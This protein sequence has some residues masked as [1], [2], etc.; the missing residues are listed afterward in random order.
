MVKMDL[1]VHKDTEGQPEK[2]VLMEIKALMDQLDIEDQMDKM[3][4]MEMKDH[5]DHKDIE[6]QMVMLD[7]MEGQEIVD[8]EEI[9]VLQANLVIVKTVTRIMII[10]PIWM[11]W[12]KDT[13]SQSTIEIDIWNEYWLLA[14]NFAMLI[15]I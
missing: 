13:L 1:M 11:K 5:K 14:Y 15:K 2:M 8:Q 4:L 3:E 12:E 10:M 9:E 6:D 7:L